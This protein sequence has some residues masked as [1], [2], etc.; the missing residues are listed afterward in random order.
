MLA[1]RRFL[2][3]LA[4]VGVAVMWGGSYLGA[5]ELAQAS[6]APAVMCARFVPAALILLVLAAA[7]RKRAGLRQVIRPGLALGVLRAATIALETIGVTRTSA[8]NAGLIIGLSVL[9]TPILES[10][11]T[12][13]RLSTA[14]VMSMLLG[15]VG[16]AML[17]SGG[18]FTAPSSGDLLVL[19]AALTRAT[20]GVAE[21]RFTRAADADVL[22]L[23]TIE[24]C[25]GA[26]V[27]ALWGGHSAVTHAPAFTA[28]DWANLAYLSIG[29]TVLAFLGQL[30]ATKHS[31]ASRAGLILG[32]EPGWALAV[33]AVVA[34]ERLS[35]LGLIGG[36][37]LLGAV[38][39]GGRAERR[40]RAGKSLPLDPAAQ[41][42]VRAPEL[43]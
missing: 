4:L 22:G 34:G 18:G 7:R 35:A 28:Q 20:L 16:I 37:V 31:S 10:A 19:A 40:W 27:F 38:T 9:I 5:K 24:L 43:V 11:A 8:T 39:W 32:T 14:L 21:A 33:G 3:D 13:R 26:I 23:T 42:H 25:F 2:P 12:R 36:L 41:P 15:L 30:W 17:V 29:C 1:L 6:S